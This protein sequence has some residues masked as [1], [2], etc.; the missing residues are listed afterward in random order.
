MVIPLLLIW[1]RAAV[2]VI[3]LVSV[4]LAFDIRVELTHFGICEHKKL[5]RRC[6]AGVLMV[7]MVSM[8]RCQFIILLLCLESES[9]D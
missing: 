1:L 6:C 4:V 9:W 8:L 5:P 3:L 7:L 2:R